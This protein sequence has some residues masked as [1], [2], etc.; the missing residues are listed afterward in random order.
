MFTPESRAATALD[1]VNR[2]LADLI[3]E[4][5]QTNH[6]LTKL[7]EKVAPEVQPRQMPKR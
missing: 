4:T 3:R 6:L 7:L 5:K 2:N 1:N